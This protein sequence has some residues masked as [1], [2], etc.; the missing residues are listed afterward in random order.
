MR[1]ADSHRCQKVRALHVGSIKKSGEQIYKKQLQGDAGQ[2]AGVFFL[3]MAAR[4]AR[5][6]ASASSSLPS[7]SSF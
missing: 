5:S 1:D 4:C 2:E 6:R 3:R 7:S